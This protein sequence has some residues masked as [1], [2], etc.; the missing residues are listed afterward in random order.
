MGPRQLQD[1]AVTNA[2]F[3]LGL[4]LAYAVAYP[5]CVPMASLRRGVVEPAVCLAPADAYAGA[6]FVGFQL[7]VLPGA[8]AL[9]LSLLVAWY[10][11]AALRGEE[12]WL[13]S[14]AAGAAALPTGLLLT[15]ALYQLGPG[16]LTLT[17][18][19]AVALVALL[20]LALEGVRR[21]TAR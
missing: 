18:G 5:T 3:A 17:F 14:L 10:G 2:A 8:V 11:P 1:L 9:G 7:G 19:V 15:N 20:T 6:L 4:T 21:G 16:A 13:A 12:A